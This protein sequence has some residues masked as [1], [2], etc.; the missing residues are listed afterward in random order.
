VGD[1]VHI[2][3]AGTVFN[4]R[5]G[6]TNYLELSRADANLGFDATTLGFPQSLVSQLPAAALGGMFPRIDIDQFEHLARGTGPRTN[7][8]Y[9]F[10][11]NIS[12]TRGR[13]NIRGGLDLR[14]TNVYSDNYGNAGGTIGFNRDFTRSVFGST[15]E[16]TGGNAFASFLLGAPSSGEVPVNLF[17]HFQWTFAAPWVQDDWRVNNKL[18]L[19]LGFRIDYNSPVHEE[20]NRLNYIFDTTILNPV[21]S[22]VG[23]PVRGGLTFAGVDGNPDTPWKLDKNNYQGRVGTAYQLNEKTVL[24]AGY[25][26]Y[27][28]N[29]TGEGFTNGFSLATPLIAS[30]D[31]GRTPTYALSNPFPNG[32]QTPPGSSLG[33]LTFLGRGPGFS[34]PDFV[35]PNVHQFSAGFQREMPWKVSLEG[36]YAGSRTYDMQSAWNGFNEPSQDFQR[37]CD[38]TLGGN[39]NFCDQLLPNPFFGVAG[40]EGTTRFTNPTLSRFELSRPFPA[41]TGINMTER[42]DG[43]LVYDSLQVVAN[44]RWFKGLTLNGNY[45]WVPRWTETGTNNGGQAFIDNVSQVPVNGPYFSQRK[46]RITASGVWELPWRDRRDLTGMFLGGWSISPFFVYQSGQPWD[47]P[48][49][50]LIVDPSVAAL[51]GKKEGQ[52]IYGAKPCVGQRNATTG[53]YDLLAFSTAYG[54]TEPYFLIREPFQ[55][56]TT[57]LRYDEFRRPSYWDLTVAFSKTTPITDKMRFQVRLEAFNLFNSP[58]Y[59]E[60]GYGTGTGNADFGRINRNTNAQ[61]NFPRAFQLGFKL[62]F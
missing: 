12:A 40:F 25:G 51:S 48:D 27:Y 39:R 30:N 19:N 32:V 13:H 38:V 58:M 53:K 35:V 36:S 31:G 20:Q 7:K 52:F 5:F 50:E 55:R 8:N 34:N 33:A 23:Q 6:Y 1:W 60:R 26:K 56:R 3:G 37:Q 54:C 21:S 24:R 17:P 4:M 41:F 57:Q 42:N 11:P 10:Q 44:K 22:R 14:Y 43:K 29:P 62:I 59:D 49:L 16:S 47:M 46:H 9:S 18:T 45:T 15:V 61:S 2:L 28:L